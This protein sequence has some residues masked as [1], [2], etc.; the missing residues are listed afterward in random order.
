M[1]RPSRRRVLALAGGGTVLA[2][3]AGAGAFAL[4]RTPHAALAPW[5]A[6]GGYAD[7]RMVDGRT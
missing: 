1:S 4:T 6:A 2:A 7:A 3:T 5:E